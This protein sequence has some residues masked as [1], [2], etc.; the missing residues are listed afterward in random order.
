MNDGVF[1]NLAA[2]PDGGGNSTGAWCVG[3]TASPIS[4]EADSSFGVIS[5]GNDSIYLAPEE[6]LKDAPP[7]YASAQ[8]DA[9]P[10]YWETTTIHSLP[11]FPPPLFL[12]K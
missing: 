12:E 10:P 3:R 7:S 11:A 2:K 4:L 1:F 8:A 9:V 5:D 6:T